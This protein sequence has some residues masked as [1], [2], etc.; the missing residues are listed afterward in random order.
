MSNLKLK[1][2]YDFIVLG[3]LDSIGRFIGSRR[4]KKRPQIITHNVIPY[5][6]SILWLFVALSVLIFVSTLYLHY[7]VNPLLS[8]TFGR[9][10]DICSN[11]LF[12]EATRLYTLIY[13]TES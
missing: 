1:P 5:S 4:R 10:L 6:F 2:N 8:L 13:V 7:T 9:M 11:G 3:H 12:L